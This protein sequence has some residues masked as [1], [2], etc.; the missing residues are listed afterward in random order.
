[1][2]N[3]N[4][5]PSSIK[6]S[7]LKVGMKVIHST[8]NGFIVKNITIESDDILPI[9]VESK[10]GETFRFYP[11]ESLY[12]LGFPEIK[13]GQLFYVSKSFYGVREHATMIITYETN[14]AFEGRRLSTEYY[15]NNKFE[16]FLR[17]PVEHIFKMLV[18]GDIHPVSLPN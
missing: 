10:A 11:D 13:A 2:Y 7:D 18:D 6:A 12:S 17:L 9:V 8:Y 15:Y 5:I 1:M 14:N 4:Y 3:E 16:R